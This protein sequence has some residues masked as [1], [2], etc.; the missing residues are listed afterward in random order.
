MQQ[1]LALVH[2]ATI[3]INR[4][5]SLHTSWL[6][7]MGLLLVVAIMAPSNHELAQETPFLV[8]EDHHVVMDCLP[9]ELI[10][11]LVV[12]EAPQCPSHLMIL[13]SLV[14]LVRPI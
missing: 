7:A 13:M 2:Q 3:T 5:H 9:A 1:L 10:V 8:A 4:T 12:P 14:A 6:R 11:L